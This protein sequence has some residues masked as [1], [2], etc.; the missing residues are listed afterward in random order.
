LAGAGLYGAHRAA[1]R[2][3]ASKKDEAMVAGGLLGLT[4]V[5]IASK[6]VWARYRDSHPVLPKPISD[7]ALLDAIAAKVGLNPA[8]GEDVEE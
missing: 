3:G 1:E 5:V 4:G 6:Y 2:I 7:R 8:T